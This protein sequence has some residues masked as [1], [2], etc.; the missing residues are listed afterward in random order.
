MNVETHPSPSA[1]RQLWQRGLRAQ[2]D[3]E[4]DEAMRL[5]RTSLE[6]HETAEAW[7]FLGWG[8]SFQG[9][10]DDAVDACL[11]A[12]ELDPGLG[13]P[14]NDIGAY[15]VEQDRD[16]EAVLW[17]QRA[18]EAER[19]DTPQFPYLNLARLHIHRGRLAAALLELQVAELLA[20]EDPRVAQLVARVGELMSEAQARP[21]AR[22]S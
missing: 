19:Y 21:L 20:P 13:N 8:L 17:F 16:E 11:R 7:A 6:L 15:L 4:I 22:A 3:G 5:Y 18:K 2:L 1:A 9:L 12:I 14:Y 10:L